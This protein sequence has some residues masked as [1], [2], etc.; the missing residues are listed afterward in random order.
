MNASGLRPAHTFY[1]YEQQVCCAIR[2]NISVPFWMHELYYT[3]F[4]CVKQEKIKYRNNKVRRNNRLLFWYCSY[5]N[6][7]QHGQVYLPLVIYFKMSSER[8]S[9]MRRR[10]MCGFFFNI[11]VDLYART[12]QTRMEAWLCAHMLFLL[13]QFVAVVGVCILHTYSRHKDK[14]LT[15]GLF[16]QS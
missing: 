3:Y 4:G 2:V 16:D 12:R 11:A 6:S 9:F 5:V 13:I 10:R 15:L 8:L 14:Y 1:V 7:D